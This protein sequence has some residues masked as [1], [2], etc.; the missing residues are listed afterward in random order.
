MDNTLACCH[1]QP[2][3]WKI[4]IKD[5]KGHKNLGLG[6]SFT[7]TSQNSHSETQDRNNPAGACPWKQI[8]M[9]W[10]SLPYHKALCIC[11]LTCTEQSPCWPE[12]QETQNLPASTQCGGHWNFSS[13]LSGHLGM[14][15]GLTVLEKSSGS[16]QT[17]SKFYKHCSADSFESKTILWDMKSSL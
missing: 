17:S 8:L 16:Y 10:I 13:S 7:G 1:L 11:V 4:L 6:C 9:Q 3:E 12:S 14:C 2:M 5:F 15:R